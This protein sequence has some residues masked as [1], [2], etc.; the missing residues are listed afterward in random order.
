MNEIKTIG[1]WEE[2]GESEEQLFLEQETN[3]GLIQLRQDKAKNRFAIRA[4]I[5]GKNVMKR[6]MTLAEALNAIEELKK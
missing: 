4:S 6:G 5:G 3:S 2:M 1:K